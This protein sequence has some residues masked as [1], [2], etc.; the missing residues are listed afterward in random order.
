MSDPSTPIKEIVVQYY[1]KHHAP[2]PSY[3]ASGVVFTRLS[4]YFDEGSDAF[5]TEFPAGTPRELVAAKLKALA[6]AIT[7]G[8]DYD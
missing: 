3:R 8:G 2:L 1:D 4:I 5:H 6:E 7:E